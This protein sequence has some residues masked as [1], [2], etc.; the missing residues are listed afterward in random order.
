MICGRGMTITLPAGFAIKLRHW[1]RV[2]AGPIWA[3]FTT[4]KKGRAG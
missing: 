3:T 1:G 2:N 4:R